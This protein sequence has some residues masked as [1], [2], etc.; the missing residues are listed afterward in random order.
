MVQKAK[1]TIT[2]RVIKSWKSSLIGFA[3]VG[4]ALYQ[5]YQGAEFD[6][7]LTPLG[8]GFGLLGIMWKE[9]GK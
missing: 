6:T 7:I 1:R 2:A 9:P 4:Y 3:I 5:Y 8:M